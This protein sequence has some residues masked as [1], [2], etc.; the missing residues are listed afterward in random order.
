M[1]N[2]CNNINSI[3]IYTNI[4]SECYQ[5]IATEWTRK[6]AKVNTIQNNC[7]KND[8]MEICECLFDIQEEISQSRFKMD[9]LIKLLEAQIQ[10]LIHLTDIAYERYIFSKK[11]LINEQTI[12]EHFRNRNQTLYETLNKN[13]EAIIKIFDITNI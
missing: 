3:F 2:I 1:I 13:Y 7:H 10:E 5:R 4:N 12:V 6:Y 8:K 9:E 11:S